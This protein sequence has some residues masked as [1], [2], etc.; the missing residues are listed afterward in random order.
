MPNFE[1]P[2]Y[3]ATPPAATVAII[4]RML[5]KLDD[6][7]SCMQQGL[8]PGHLASWYDEVIRLARG[9]APPHLRDK[10]GVVQ[11]PVLP[12]RFS[13]DISRRAVGYFM[14]AV[15]ESLDGMPYTT[16]LYFL[17]VQQ[18]MSREADRSLA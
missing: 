8:Q 16:R 14:A 4:N 5:K 18:A 2:R 7:V 6:D 10:I 11:D 1:L 13:L 12:M 9:Y 17:R 3:S 15:D